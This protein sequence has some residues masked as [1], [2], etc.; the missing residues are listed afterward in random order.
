MGNIINF[1]EKLGASAELQELS[2]ADVLEMLQTQNLAEADT[3]EFHSTIE[4]MLDAR[5]K[6]V[7]GILPAEEPKEEP[8]PQDV[9]E[10]PVPDKDE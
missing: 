4:K 10:Q 1:M 8:E 7:C 5:K 6:L 2:E 3:G 9:P